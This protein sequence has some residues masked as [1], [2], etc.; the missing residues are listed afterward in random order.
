[1]N[2]VSA[3]LRWLAAGLCALLCACATPPKPEAP[4]AAIA[5]SALGLSGAAAP[6]VSD[7]WWQGFGDAQLDR[8]IEQA[9]ERQP[10]SGTGRRRDCGWPRRRPKPPTP[11]QLPGRS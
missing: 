9:R 7:T 4:H 1:M 10:G 8:L 5:D 3:D 11:S 2:T 6:A